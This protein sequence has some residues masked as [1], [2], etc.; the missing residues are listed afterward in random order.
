[1]HHIRLVAFD[2]L[3]TI[4]TPR[5][6]IY[7]Q[8]SQIFTPYVGILPPESIKEAFKAAMR[9]VQREKPVYGGDTKQ[10]WGDVIRRTA[11][12]AG[13]READVEQNLAEIIDKLMLRF[14]SREG[15][16]AFEDA[17]PTIQRLHQMGLKTIVISNGDIRFKPIVLSEAVGAEKPSKQIFQSALNAV[18][19][20]LNPGENVF[21]AKECLHI[22]DELT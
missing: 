21:Q 13:A 18:N 1:M 2:V 5:Q 15:Y 9:H 17:I 16:K 22:G 4:I 7:E 3:H 11:L 20:H 10:W 19:L 6:P 14:S 12:G 8:Y